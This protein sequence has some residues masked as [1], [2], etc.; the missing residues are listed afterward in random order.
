MRPRKS[1]FSAN[2]WCGVLLYGGSILIS[3]HASAQTCSGTL[4]SI[5]YNG[6]YSSTAAGG[7]R[8]INYSL[9]QFPIFPSTLYAVQISSY[10]TVNVTIHIQ[11]TNATAVNAKIQL[12][13]NDDFNEGSFDV[14][15]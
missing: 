10:I 5:T 2:Y 1:L 11:N 3:S 6:N 9:P 13:R 14:N 7:D 15:N 8:T 4:K 12:L